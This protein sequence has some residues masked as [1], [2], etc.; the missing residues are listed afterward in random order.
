MI[1]KKETSEYE[2][3]EIIDLINGRQL[4]LLIIEGF[5]SVVG[6]RKDI[7]RI[8]TAETEEELRKTLG[9]TIAPVLAITGPLAK[10]KTIPAGA[11]TPL[12]T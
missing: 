12:L 9:R 6:Q 10:L 11:K 2:L 1:R 7:P 4:D 3:E 8:V 5:H